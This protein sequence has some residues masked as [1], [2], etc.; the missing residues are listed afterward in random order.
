[1]QFL[2]ILYLNNWTGKWLMSP[3]SVITKLKKLYEQFH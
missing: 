3:K 2:V 1:M